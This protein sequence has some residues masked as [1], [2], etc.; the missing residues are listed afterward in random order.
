MKKYSLADNLPPSERVTL[1]D[2]RS[3]LA[4]AGGDPF[5]VHLHSFNQILWFRAGSGT[6]LVDFVEYPYGPQT[7]LYVPHGGACL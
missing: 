3:Y 5:E 6:H 1:D 2:L 4:R 7:L